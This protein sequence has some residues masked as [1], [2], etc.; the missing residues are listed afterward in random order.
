M[1]ISYPRSSQFCL[2][3]LN[4]RDKIKYILVQ[5]KEIPELVFEAAVQHFERPSSSG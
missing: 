5:A 2:K 3:H 4:H 1:E